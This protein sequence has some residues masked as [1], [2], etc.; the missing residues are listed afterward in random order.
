MLLKE[1]SPL[2]FLGFPKVS[3]Y[4]ECKV[5]LLYLQIFPSNK[6]SIS[7]N[8]VGVAVGNYFVLRECRKIVI[9]AIFLIIDF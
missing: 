9:S 4:S 1:T 7:G 2:F 8:P 5:T 6:K 3:I